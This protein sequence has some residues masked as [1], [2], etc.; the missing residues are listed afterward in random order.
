MPLDVFSP[1]VLLQLLFCGCFSNCSFIS[2]AS[3]SDVS[4]HVIATSK[5]GQSGDWRKGLALEAADAAYHKTEE[6][7]GMAVFSRRGG[8]ILQYQRDRYLFA[9]VLK[10][11]QPN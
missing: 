2:A 11:M 4:I 3:H 1:Q 9:L 10:T 5:Q 6:E 7:M 8:C